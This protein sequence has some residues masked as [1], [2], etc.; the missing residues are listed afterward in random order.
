MHHLNSFFTSLLLFD[1]PDPALF[2]LRISRSLTCNHPFLNFPT[3]LFVFNP[4]SPVF[5]AFAFRFFGKTSPA[6]LASLSFFA[7]LR[8]LAVSMPFRIRRGIFPVESSFPPRWDIRESR[9]RWR[10]RPGLS[11]SLYSARIFDSRRRRWRAMSFLRFS[12]SSSEEASAS[13]S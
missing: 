9:V 13:A 4:R 7:C 12:V 10:R 11:Q 5:T 2:I 8:T 6:S 1:I 3:P